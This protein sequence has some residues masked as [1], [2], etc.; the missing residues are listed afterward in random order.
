[1]QMIY[2]YSGTRSERP[3]GFSDVEDVTKSAERRR[4]RNDSNDSNDLQMCHNWTGN[5]YRV[6][7]YKENA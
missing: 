2:M 5:N 7:K 6:T 1:M 3:Q 4:K